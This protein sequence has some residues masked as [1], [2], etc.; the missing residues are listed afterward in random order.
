MSFKTTKDKLKLILDGLTGSGADK[1]FAESFAYLEPSPEQFPCAMIGT[2]AGSGEE[3]ADTAY[4]TTNMQ[5]IIRCYLPNKND[6]ATHDLLLTTL[7]GLLAELRKDSNFTLGG[8]VQKV[9]P[10]KQIA[11]YYTDETEEPVI[12]FDV[13]VNVLKLN[14][15]F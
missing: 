10:G 12:G 5:F 3:I 9:E 8:T 2:F 1:L 13:L 4:N 6:L 15:T 14:Q 7:D 11:V